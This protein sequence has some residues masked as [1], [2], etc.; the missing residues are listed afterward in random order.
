MP[1]LGCG[2]PLRVADVRAGETVLDLG[3]GAGLDLLISSGRV[4]AAGRVIG[5][6]MTPDMVGLARRNTAAAGNVEVRLGRIEHIPLPDASVD[7]VISNCVLNLT[8]DKGVVLREVAR[9]LRPGGR[10]GIT[11]CSP[12]RTPT[13]PAHRRCRR[14]R[15]R[16]PPLTAAAYEELLR[17]AGL[18]EVRI[19]PAQDAGGGIVTA[20]V[21]AVKP[22]VAIRAMSG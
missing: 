21:Q 7:V 19:E 4:G 13:P 17:A 12:P 9:V 5:L 6:D 16:G 1:S 20:I 22:T 14:H 8:A 11:T 10:I 18:I 2:N 15:H 3:S